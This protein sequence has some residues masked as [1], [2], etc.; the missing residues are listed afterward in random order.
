VPP[1]EP[2]GPRG[3]PRAPATNHPELTVGQAIPDSGSPSRVE[4][5]EAM[6]RREIAK[7]RKNFENTFRRRFGKTFKN[8]V[9]SN[10]FSG[11]KHR[12]CGFAV[13]K[14]TPLQNDPQQHQHEAKNRKCRV[15]RGGKWSPDSESVRREL[16]KSDLASDVGQ[17]LRWGHHGGG[18]NVAP[19][20]AKA[21]PVSYRSIIENPPYRLC[22]W[23]KYEG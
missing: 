18:T 17:Q 14:M 13:S 15:S 22:C 9:V 3:G 6:E 21:Q 12:I 23:G 20:P 16:S 1:G 4:T 5:P 7:S 11:E 19:G 8:R 2:R 10:T